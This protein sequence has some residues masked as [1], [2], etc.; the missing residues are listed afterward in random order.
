MLQ[1]FDVAKA[2][3]SREIEGLLAS[4]ENKGLITKVS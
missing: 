4:L 1:E 2:D 3:L